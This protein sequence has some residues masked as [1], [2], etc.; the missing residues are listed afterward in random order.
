MT[1]I[2]LLPWREEARKERQKQFVVTTLLSLVV[3]AGV[4]GLIHIQIDAMIS[5]QNARND[6]LK[7]EIKA[8]DKKIAEIQDLE[9]T[10]NKLIE[11]MKVIQQLQQ[12]RPTIVHVFDELVRTV[13]DG[14]YLQ[15]L[16]QNNN[17][18]DITGEADSNARVSAYMRN[19]DAS[20][21][22]KS[23][24][25]DVIQVRDKKVDRVSSFELKVKQTSPDAEKKEEEGEATQ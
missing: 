25:L 7:T 12:S 14:V 21:W 22:L 5:H 10:R 1:R 11:R 6:F 3:T 17:V 19:L 23:P 13:P 16:K 24:G 15:S 18:L 4:V 8:L 20:E 2:N 9:K